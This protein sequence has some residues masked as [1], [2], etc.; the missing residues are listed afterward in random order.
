[1]SLS[2]SLTTRDETANSNCCGKFI[3]LLN[4]VGEG[5]R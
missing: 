3:S 5:E 1:M 2:L 4:Q